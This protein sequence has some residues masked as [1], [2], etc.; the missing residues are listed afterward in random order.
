MRDGLLVRE[1]AGSM[2]QERLYDLQELM[3]EKKDGG[4]SL[5]SKL[6]MAFRRRYMKTWAVTFP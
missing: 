1:I 2:E 6:V 5:R 4:P 3:R